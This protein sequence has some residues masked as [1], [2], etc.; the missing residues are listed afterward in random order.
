MDNF[1]ILDA[2]RS[3]K[4]LVPLNAEQVPEEDLRKAVALTIEKRELLARQVFAHGRSHVIVQVMIFFTALLFVV[5]VATVPIVV[6]AKP[7]T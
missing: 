3:N 4:K 2:Y 7:L 1:H 6:P 5:I